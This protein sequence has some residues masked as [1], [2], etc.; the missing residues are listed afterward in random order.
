MST[1][2]N[3]A[4]EPDELSLDIRIVEEGDAVEAL[5][6]STDNGCDT[7]KQGDC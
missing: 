6:C 4:I 3:T 7:Q 2:Q 5:L 1:T